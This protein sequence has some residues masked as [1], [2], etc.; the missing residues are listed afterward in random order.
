MFIGPPMSPG[1]RYPFCTS[2]QGANGPS[3]EKAFARIANRFNARRLITASLFEISRSLKDEFGFG[4]RLDIC[5]SFV[6]GICCTYCQFNSIHFSEE[7]PD[8]ILPNQST[9]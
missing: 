8:G 9:L 4:L 2:I 7:A 5:A 6:C 3:K 1:W